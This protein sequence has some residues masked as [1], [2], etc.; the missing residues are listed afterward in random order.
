MSKTTRNPQK[1]QIAFF[2]N[3]I[4]PFSDAMLERYGTFEGA[5]QAMRLNPKL[6]QEMLKSA[7]LITNYGDNQMQWV[8]KTY[9]LSLP[10]LKKSQQNLN[11]AINNVIAQNSPSTPA[12]DSTLTGDNEQLDVS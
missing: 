12:D 4:I 1:E 6:L 11:D 8:A 9:S 2:E 7:N 5:I 3:I 10:E